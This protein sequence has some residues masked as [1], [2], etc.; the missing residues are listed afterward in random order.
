MRT[1]I[2]ASTLGAALLLQACSGGEEGA[3][4]APSEAAPVAGAP[5]ATPATG[6][7][8]QATGPFSTTG[9]IAAVEADAVS[10]NHQPVAEL[11]WP[12]M[13]MTFQAPD[14]SMIQGLQAGAPVRFSF[15]KQG[16]QYV[17]TEVR[18]Q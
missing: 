5:S 13:T 6:G 8:A 10:I 12:A 14:P 1:L 9:Q 2:I 4:E 11:G 15:S 3:A 7:A 17:L 16:D 18:P